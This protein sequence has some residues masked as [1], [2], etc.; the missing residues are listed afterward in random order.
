LPNKKQILGLDIGSSSVRAALFD[1]AGDLRPN[2][3]VKIE[4][5][6]M[7][8][9]GGGSEID[10]D[11]ALRQVMTAIDNVIAK[12]GKAEINHVASCTFWHSLLGVDSDCRPTTPVLGWADNRSRDHV[13]TLRKRFAESEVH[14]RTGARFHPSF[15]PAKLLWLRKEHADLWAKTARWISFGDYINFKVTGS[16]ATSVSIASGT[17]IFD[18]RSSEWDTEMLR[19]LKVKRSSLP[20][21]TSSDNETFSLLPKWRKRWPALKEARLIPSVADGAAN[22]IGSG[23]LTSERAALMIGTSGAMRVVYPG[24]PPQSIPS[25]LF[26]YRVDRKRVVVGGALSDG[27]GLCDWLKRNLRIDLSDKEIGAEI[28]RR[29]AAAHG[30][31]FMPFFA[32]ERS[33]GYDEFA[34][35][36]I[37]GLTMSHDAIDILQAAME[38]VAY[39]FVDIFDQL[40]TVCPVRSIVASGGALTRSPVWTQIIA[41]VLGHDLLLSSEPEASLR[42]AVLLARESTGKMVN[43]TTDSAADQREIAVD[44][45]RHAVY[46]QARERHRNLYGLNFKPNS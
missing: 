8:T 20:E 45:K 1:N 29:A 22:N 34:T 38:A 37:S 46:R 15:W 5:R 30:L 7:S 41:D 36:S 28:E 21:V 14:N 32:G 11:V 40:K 16:F 44:K 18:I 31:K 27:G 42:G 19:Y 12:A 3:F 23:C 13:G 33:T 39:R 10:A 4:R 17:G 26:L 2:T 25:G 9:A 6:L 24:E 35:G 43:I